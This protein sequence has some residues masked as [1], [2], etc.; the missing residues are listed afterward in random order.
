MQRFV[1]TS[2]S[3]PTGHLTADRA[4]TQRLVWASNSWP[5]GHLTAGCCVATHPPCERTNVWPGE[6]TFWAA[7][8]GTRFAPIPNA[9]NTRP[10]PKSKK[11]A[12]VFR[13]I[14][15]LLIERPREPE[16]TDRQNRTRQ[17]P[18]HTATAVR[19]RGP[20]ARRTKKGRLFCRYPTASAVRLT[21]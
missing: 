21:R 13:F 19:D 18:Y 20:T 16:M 7:A 4:V 5:S 1:R 14:T 12:A 10:T 8:V 11:S 9:A 17:R 2:N 6:Q 3:W 15:P